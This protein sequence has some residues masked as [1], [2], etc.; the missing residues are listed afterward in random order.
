[1]LRPRLAS[2]V[3]AVVMGF[4]LHAFGSDDDALQEKSRQPAGRM[5]AARSTPGKEVKKPLTV[6]LTQILDTLPFLLAEQN[7]DFDE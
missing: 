5:E 2:V 6:A 7:G 4:S 1:M 3:L